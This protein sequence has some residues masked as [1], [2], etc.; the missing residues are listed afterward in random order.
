[1]SKFFFIESSV[2][3]LIVKEEVVGGGAAV[4]TLVWMNAL[5]HQGHQV[6][7]A[8]FEN[9]NR[10]LK[11][12][13]RNLRLINTY[14]TEKG[15]R[16][17][18]WVY[19]RYPRIYKALKKCKPDFLYE[20]IPFWGSF[21]HSFICRSLGIKHVIRISND[22]L[23]DKRLRNTASKAHQFFLFWGL[24]TCDVILSQNDYQYQTLR[25]KF[26]NK[27]ILKIHNPIVI[28]KALLSPKAEHQKGYFAWLANFRF[29]KNLKLLHEIALLLPN[30]QFKVAGS[31]NKNI[32]EESATYLQKLKELPNVEIL[33]PVRR[34]ALFTF[35]KNA[36]YLLNTSR[37][38]GFSNTFLEA[39]VAGTPILTT[40]AVNPDMIVSKNKLGL[41][42]QN[43]EEL[44]ALLAEIDKE[45]YS[46]LS[47]N[48]VDFVYNNH[49]HLNLANRLLT[50]LD[51]PIATN[52]EMLVSPKIKNI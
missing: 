7:L 49:D 42:Y 37:Y 30:E 41:I 50:F 17:L 15:V 31:P 2:K 43:P 45:K 52:Q 35:L 21:M 23:L 13:Y 9:D 46:N 3:G 24:K 28:D 32:D 25:K 26:P 34:D 48:C 14:D 39:M 12:A 20:S 44:I 27:Q 22:N 19:Y 38:E 10:E 1:M 51:A 4:Q 16:W 47:R 36:K 8:N 33:G 40:P 18:R 6:F 29:Q 11:D 5:K